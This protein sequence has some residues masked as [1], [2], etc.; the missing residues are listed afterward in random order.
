MARDPRSAYSNVTARK[1]GLDCHR[2]AACWNAAIR[3]QS[4]EV[5]PNPKTQEIAQA[6]QEGRQVE[7]PDEWLKHGN[8]WEFVRAE[9][10]YP[11]GFGGKLV[12]GADVGHFAVTLDDH[13]F[14]TGR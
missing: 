5:I 12:I 1:S 4:S 7:L 9:L 10:R 11:V 8:P 14:P 6:I 13:R 3:F 2:A